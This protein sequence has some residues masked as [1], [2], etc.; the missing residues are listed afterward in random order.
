MHVNSAFRSNNIDDGGK[1]V[2][3]RGFAFNIAIFYRDRKNAIRSRFQRHSY[4]VR[5]AEN[6]VWDFGRQASDDVFTRTGLGGR[7]GAWGQCWDWLSDA[8]TRI[9]LSI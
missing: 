4:I 5:D 8:A 3:G 6:G 1:S 2:V 7:L 9:Y